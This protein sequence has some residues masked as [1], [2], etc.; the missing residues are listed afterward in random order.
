MLINNMSIVVCR[1]PKTGLGNQLFP[2]LKAYLFADLNKFPVK[3]TGYNQFKIGPYLRGD[4][5]KRKYKGYFTFEKGILGEQVDRYMLLKYRHYEVLPEPGICKLINAKGKQLYLF[6]RLPHWSDYFHELKDH[7]RLVIKLFMSVLAPRILDKFNQG[8]APF[9][10]L[11]ARMGDFRKLKEGE[12]FSN[13]GVVRTPI[14]YFIY[15]VK[16]IR[17]IHG[18]DLPVSIFTDGHAYELKELL[19]LANIQVVEGNPDIVDLLLLSKSKIIITSAGSTFSY[20]AG[21]LSDAA[22]IMHPD[23]IYQSIRPGNMQ[24]RFYE[25]PFDESNTL[26]V[27]NIKAITWTKTQ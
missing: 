20:W 22:L 10:G 2:L 13:S 8:Q 19:H 12:D 25:G 14:E 24:Q 17:S 16:G 23:H 4:K 9:I 15:V 11:H 7:R 26:L 1:L 27:N 5:S 6:Y 21:F 3:V 18:S